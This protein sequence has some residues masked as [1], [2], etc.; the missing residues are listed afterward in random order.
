MKIYFQ[1]QTAF[2][3]KLTKSSISSA[4]ERRVRLSIVNAR[5]DRGGKKKNGEKKMSMVYG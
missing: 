2:L 3:K 1:N 4:A 5:R